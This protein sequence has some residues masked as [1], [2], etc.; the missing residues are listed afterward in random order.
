MKLPSLAMLLL[1]LS[2]Q[3]LSPLQAIDADV[4]QLIVGIAPGWDS[5]QGHIQWF[6]RDSGK[7]WQP[8]SGQIPVLF[9]KNGLAW[10]RG[11]EG[12]DEPGRHKQEH[13]GRAPARGVQYRD[14]LHL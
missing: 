14:D 3:P 7:A 2:L 13:D 12:T 9:G 4:H 10:G 6:H 11:V 1:V 8:A 5:M